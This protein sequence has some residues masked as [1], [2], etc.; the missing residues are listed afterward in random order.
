M[1]HVKHADC[2]SE[3]RLLTGYPI[4]TRVLIRAETNLPEDL[5]AELG[6]DRLHRLQPEGRQLFRRPAPDL[7]C[8]CALEIFLIRHRICT[9]GSGAA[10]LTR[11]LRD[12]QPPANPKEWGGA[13]NHDRRRPE[14][15]HDHPVKPGSVQRIPA[16]DL[17]PLMRHAHPILQGAGDHGSV[18]E[19][20]P[21]LI[22]L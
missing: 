10:G 7:F 9:R 17:C 14:G 20:G 19:L 1:F 8:D 21:A 4:S 12:D 3:K 2:S 13:F 6:P 16:A 11:R 15:T 5:V 22:R 18:E